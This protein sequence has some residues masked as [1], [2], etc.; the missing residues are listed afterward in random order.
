[1]QSTKIFRE[2]PFKALKMLGILFGAIFLFFT[3]I[4]FSDEMPQINADGLNS[5]ASVLLILLGVFGGFML[6]TFLILS[7]QYRKI[8]KCD[9]EGCEIMESTFWDKNGL[10]ITGF[11]WHEVKDTTIIET[12]LDVPDGGIV[13]IYNFAVETDE[14]QINL[15]ELKTSSKNNIEGLINYINKATP[16][17]KYVWLKDKKVGNRLVIDSVYKYSKV[18]R[19]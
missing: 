8:L 9:F 16:H 10:P 15:L 19:N 3:Y 12:E 17:L 7:F 14:K 18:A 6:L 11:K 1:M 13:S 2:S 4:T 5:S